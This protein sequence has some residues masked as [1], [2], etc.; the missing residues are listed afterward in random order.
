MWII[1]R[2][3]KI[4][5]FGIVTEVEVHCEINRKINPVSASV[6]KVLFSW[7]FFRALII[8]AAPYSWRKFIK[9]NL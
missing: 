8:W 6:Q 1:L 3:L 2:Y 7:I 4:E 9:Q 5:V